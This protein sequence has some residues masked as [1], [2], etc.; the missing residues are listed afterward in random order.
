M[1]TKSTL[2]GWVTAGI[3]AAL[4]F[5]TT[6][7]LHIPTT[8]G[9]YIHVGDAI[10]YLAASL[11]P[12]QYAVPAAAIGGALSDALSPGSA[13]YIIPTLI[14]KAVIALYFTNKKD[15]IIC[16]R[17]V[18]AIFIAGITSLVLYGL[19]SFIF[20]G[21]IMAVILELPLNS[22][23]PIASGILFVLVGTAFDK[24]KLKSRF[25]L[26]FEK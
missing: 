13:A 1:K 25:N 6:Y 17:N 24:A 3:F 20:Y 9:G 11:M 2:R 5:L 19:T 8:N 23:Q 4:V 10:I 14:I 18:I 15:K 7:L 16:K 22:L 21:N 26:S 12:I